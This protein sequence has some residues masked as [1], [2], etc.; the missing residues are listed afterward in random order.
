MLDL[1]NLLGYS[2]GHFPIPNLTFQY[3]HQ[4]KS[5]P[6]RISSSYRWDLPEFPL[7]E[8]YP[9]TCNGAPCPQDL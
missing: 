7:P 8:G 3:C 9:R 5:A 1:L 2:M 6:K 4:S